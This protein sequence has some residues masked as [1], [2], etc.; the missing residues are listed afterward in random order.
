MRRLK[1][2]RTFLL[3][4]CAIIGTLASALWVENSSVSADVANTQDV[5]ALER[6]I[7][8]LEQR[9]YTLET[10]INRLEQQVSLS[11]R[12][13]VAQPGV[14]R[15]VEVTLLRSQVEMLQRR[16]NEIDCGLA[17]LDE[18]TLAPAAR[19]ARRKAGTNNIDPCRL[20][21]DAPLRLS[22]RP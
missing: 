20:N 12:P 22:A 5:T 4:L 16:L 3:V 7:S 6:R 11:E 13:S 19:E 21:A 8:Q 10:S 17:K 2:W 9:F 1:R 18:R 14:A 15:D